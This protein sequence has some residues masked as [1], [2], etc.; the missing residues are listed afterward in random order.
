MFVDRILTRRGFVIHGL[1]SVGWVMIG[2]GTFIPL[3]PAI[4]QHTEKFQIVESDTPRKN[5]KRLRRSND[6]A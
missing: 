6:R 3:R 1:G 5:P 2:A 4:A